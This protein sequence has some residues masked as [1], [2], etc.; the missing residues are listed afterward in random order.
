MRRA[1]WWGER[2]VFVA[3][4]LAL[5]ATSKPPG[6]VIH[7]K[8]SGPTTPAPSKAIALSIESSDKVTIQSS[9]VPT[10]WGLKQVPCLEPFSPGAARTCLLPPGAQV[11][12]VELH[13]S[14]GGGCNDPCTPPPS[15]HVKV[16]AT[17]VDVSIDGATS[18][19]PASLPAH[20]KGFIVSRFEVKARG[21]SFIE[22][23]MTV[24]PKGGGKALF[25]ENQ[26]CELDA[27]SKCAKCTFNVMDSALGSVHDVEVTVEAT[28]WDACSAP[29]C[30]PPKTFRIDG[31]S[32]IP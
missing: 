6:W 22:A 19:I 20:A 25:D 11:D 30:A 13:G 2:G 4:V 18:T 23:H 31:V 8:I 26:S 27:A 9:A 15:A 21:A 28:G 24:V 14:C 7:A 5:L 3:S 32:L 29:G 16:D 12:G 1:R 17:Q 10:S